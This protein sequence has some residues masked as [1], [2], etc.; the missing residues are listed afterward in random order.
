MWNICNMVV[1]S[2]LVAYESKDSRRSVHCFC[3]NSIATEGQEVRTPVERVRSAVNASW[4]WSRSDV[5]QSSAPST[6]KTAG[7]S[8]TVID[9]GIVCHESR[10][11]ICTAELDVCFV[12]VNYVVIV[13]VARGSR[14]SAKSIDDVVLKRV[15][16]SDNGIT[17]RERRIGSSK[18]RWWINYIRGGTQ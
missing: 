1:V 10:N 15:G 13:D 5:N 12:D 9:N 3:R 7:R 14:S 17:R 4:M 11:H 2:T 6:G 8:C 16:G 18:I